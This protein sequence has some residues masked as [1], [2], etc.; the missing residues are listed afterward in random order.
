MERHRD[1]GA[2]R[3]VLVWSGPTGDWTA[4]SGHAPAVEVQDHEDSGTQG[5]GQ[6]VD[7]HMDRMSGTMLNQ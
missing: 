5:N 6:H 4:L 7:R 3:P 1:A 2:G